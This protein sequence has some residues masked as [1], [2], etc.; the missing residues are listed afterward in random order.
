M[1]VIH[2][3]RNEDQQFLYETTT[4]INVGEL[5]KA[6]VV[7]HNMRMRLR[8]LGDKCRDLCNHG[9]MKKPDQQGIDSVQDEVLKSEGKELPV[10]G[11]TYNADP[12]GKRTGEA[13]TEELKLKILNE[14]QTAEAYIHKNQVVAKVPLS[15]DKMEEHLELIRAAVTIAFPAGLPE[16]DEVQMNLDDTDPLEGQAANE[17]CD[18]ENHQLWWANKALAPEKTLRDYVGRNE[19]TKVV[20]KIT[21]KGAM[22]PVR[23]QPI[24]EETQKNM[25]AYYYKKQEEHKKLMENNEDDYLN[26][27]W[28]NSQS[29]KGSLVGTGASGVRFRPGL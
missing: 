27:P 1:V 10:R 9:P 29:L 6:L 5:G 15:L 4:D 14:L 24:D 23:E 21:K 26:S 28:A 18:T 11:P 2:F 3:K 7:I 8:R 13:P 22:A 20:M 17:V 16:W 25:M 19:K 12:L